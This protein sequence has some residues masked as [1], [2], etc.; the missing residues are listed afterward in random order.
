MRYWIKRIAL[1]TGEVVT[2]RELS[3]DQ[4]LFDGPV[5]DIGDF[6]DVECR[7]RRFS[8]EVI[9]RSNPD[10]EILPLRVVEAGASLDMEFFMDVDGRRISLG[11]LKR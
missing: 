6:V 8:A 5:P 3:A 9:W 10:G 4:N 1:N 11:Q 7:G 2:E